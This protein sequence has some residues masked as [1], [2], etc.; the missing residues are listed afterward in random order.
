MPRHSLALYL[1][2]ADAGR[3]LSLSSPVPGILQTGPFPRRRKG[4]RLPVILLV[5]Q[6]HPIRQTGQ[7]PLCHLIHHLIKQ[8]R[9]PVKMK[10]M[11][12][13]QHHRLRRPAERRGQPAE[14]G[15]DRR[16]AV[17]QAELL[18]AHQGRQLSQ[19]L[20]VH[21]EHVGRTG[22]VDVVKS[23]PEG[24]DLARLVQ[25]PL[26]ICVRRIMNLIPCLLQEPHIFCFELQQKTAEIRYDQCL[27]HPSAAFF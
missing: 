26:L 23:H 25:I 2:P 7:E 10:S 24:L 3:N 21:P 18:P 13:I 5:D 11:C 12:R 17:H 16:V 4:L 22:H 27:F 9:S 6:H 19:R 15:A 14:H 20:C 8:R 1:S